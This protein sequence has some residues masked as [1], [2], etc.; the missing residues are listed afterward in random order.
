MTGGSA[1]LRDSRTSALRDKA[2]VGASAACPGRSEWASTDHSPVHD[3]AVAPGVLVFTTVFPNQVQP[4][5]GLFVRERMFRVARELPLA[6]V[7]PVPW[8]P[9]QGLIRW[10]RPS[11]R[12]MPPWREHQQGIE[13]LHPRFFSVPGLFKWADGFLMALASLHALRRLRK[14]F[15]FSIIDSHF[16]YPDGYAAT[17]LGQWLDRPVTITLR[18][19]EVSLSRFPARR[20]RILRAIERAQRVFTV[21]DSIGDHLRSLGATNEIMRVGNGVDTER[22]FPVP[23]ADARRRLGIAEGTKVL[24]SVGGLCERKGFHRVIEVLPTLRERYPDLCYL[25]VGGASPEGDWSGRL[26]SQVAGL[27]LERHVRFLGTVSPEELRWPLSAADV[28]VLATRNEGWANVFLEAMACGLPVVATDV[29]GNSEVIAGAEL[30]ALVPFGDA[31]AMEAALDEALS[32]RWNR[33][34]IR[35]WA[36]R[37][38]WD[39]RVSTLVTQ[40]TGLAG[41][42]VR[43]EGN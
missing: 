33:E 3:G 4:S 11:F 8:F 35:D 42:H 39:Q 17:L 5:F 32:R 10:W 13:V 6:V 2:V 9:F 43:S 30:G 15:D 22:F 21:A 7:A 34:T 18:G 1:D 31:G 12:P 14:R 26:R 37:N 29:G 27:G 40:F 36:E 20:R 38:S 16:A 23:Q 24:V 19:T 41:G 28:F 25:V